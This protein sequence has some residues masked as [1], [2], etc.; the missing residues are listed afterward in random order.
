MNPGQM[1]TC[2]L[3][4]RPC[5]TNVEHFWHVLWVALLSHI[6]QF[7][8][9]VN[10]PADVHVHPPGFLLNLGVQVRHL[11]YED[12]ERLFRWRSYRRD[13]QLVLN[14]V[15]HFHADS[16]HTNITLSFLSELFISTSTCKI[17]YVQFK[18]YT[19]AYLLSNKKY[20]NSGLIS[21]QRQT[22]SMEIWIFFSEQL[23]PEAQI[24][25]V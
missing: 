20:A 14:C 8:R 6:A 12:R 13:Y 23:Y 2:L 1:D 5:G 15:P 4:K 24:Q 18:N 19:L 21:M 10:P 22:W 25:T 17:I 7:G 3:R 16:T 11:L 9:D